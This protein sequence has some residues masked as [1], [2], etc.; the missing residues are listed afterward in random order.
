[1]D[2]KR[3]FLYFMVIAALALA[4]CGGNGGGGMAGGG[5]GDD[6]QTCPSGQTG[7]PP[8]CVTPG[9]TVADLFATAQNAREQAE[10]AVKA[11]TDAVAD[12]KEA[13][14]KLDVYTVMG[15][16]MKAKMNAESVLN[17]QTTVST[18][19]SQAEMAV[20][21]LTKAD[22]DA[23][24]HD[25][26]ALDNAIAAALTVAQDAVKDAKTQAGSNDL[27]TAVEN[28]VGSNKNK[29][30]TATDIQNTVSTLISNAL[31]PTTDSNNVPGTGQRVLHDAEE[32][33]SDTAGTVA[34]ARSTTAPPNTDKS[35]DLYMVDESDRQGMTW[36]QI[37]GP[38]NIMDKRVVVNDDGNPVTSGGTR[39]A[40]K[41]ASSVSGMTV[42]T[43]QTAADS[44]ADGTQVV[45][46][47]GS[48]NTYKGIP[49]TF[50][51]QGSDC[52]AEAVTDA[53]KKKLSGS[54]YFTPTDD[55]AWYTKNS[56]DTYSLETLFV[57]YGHWLSGTTT[58][59]INTFA[60]TDAG[61]AEGV[62]Y[63]LNV[64]NTGSDATTLTDTSA[65][66]TGVAAGLSYNGTNK[67]S[68]AFTADV[69]L[70]ANFGVSPTLGGT[71]SNF[72]SDNM[73]AVNSDWTVELQSRAFSG[74]FDGSTAANSGRTITNGQ[75]GAWSA[76]AYGSGA[77]VRPTGIFGGFNAH[78]SDGHAAGAY[79]V[80]K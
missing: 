74:T 15:D 4:G 27:E 38:S 53:T 51:C 75:D 41:K 68:G 1:M 72:K 59:T 46:D 36:A 5:N 32:G 54:W 56:D 45:T 47:T 21:A 22:K 76:T 35:D 34:H 3:F 11:A 40:Q 14:G 64:I 2:M 24:E 61:T 73:D 31:M 60:Y 10:D 62:N 17:A 80:R 8:N 71:V 13:S 16:S 63:E 44:V 33:A 69:S 30:R 37:V 12:A 65:T 29:P 25:N 6:T 39:T 26:D 67:H 78:F 7:T 42:T 66:Y 48:E 18:A 57:R 55:E 50:F 19:V 9:P 28:V 20:S 49:G 58:T 52:K 43:S 77:T 79:A 23:D 70:T